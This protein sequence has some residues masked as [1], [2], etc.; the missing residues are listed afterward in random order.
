MRAILLTISLLFALSTT[1][2][3][4]L[5]FS[6]PEWNFGTIEEDGGEVSHTFAFTNVTNKP[7]VITDVHTTCGCTTP[8]YSKRP[9]AAGAESTIEITYD[10]MYRPGVFSRDIT[11]HTSASNDPVVI[12]ISGE[13][14]PRKLSVERQYPYILLDGVR[15]SSL[16]TPFGNVSPDSPQQAQWEVINISS[17]SRKIEFRIENADSSHLKISSPSSLSPGESAVVNILYELPTQGE[18]YGEKND[19]IYGYIDGKM[20]RMQIRTRAYAIDNF[21]PTS[22]KGEPSGIFSEKFI[23]FGALSLSKGNLSKELA[24]ENRGSQSIYIRAIECPQG[25]EVV[26]KRGMV[27]APSDKL[28]LSVNLSKEHTELGSMVE[29]ITFILSDPDSPVV[30]VKVVGEVSR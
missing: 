3:Q 29:Y 10:P 16:Y 12:K 18:I 24:I 26:S 27:I 5:K 14:T 9:I 11:I 30:K 7:L 6:S 23:N 15:I 4:S 13:A 20:S 19:Y 8:Q 2:A 25:I 17:E 1:S 21:D 22:K 28:T